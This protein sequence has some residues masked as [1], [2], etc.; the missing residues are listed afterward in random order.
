M[1][2][3]TLSNLQIAQISYTLCL[4]FL[5]ST[6]SACLPKSQ[7]NN[8]PVAIINDDMTVLVGSSVSLDSTQ[9]YDLD[10]DDL[11]FSWVLTSSPAASAISLENSF[12]PSIV[13]IPDTEG[14][15]TIELIVNDGEKDSEVTSVVVTAKTLPEIEISL[16]SGQGEL[17]PGA[18]VYLNGSIG[19]NDEEHFSYEWSLI[20]QPDG[21]SIVVENTNSLSF[22]FIPDTEGTFAF[23]LT[24]TDEGLVKDS[25]PFELL[26][27]QPI[28]DNA[29]P[30]ANA[31]AD[32]NVKTG[33]LVTLDGSVSS[34]LDL[35][36]ITYQWNIT[37]KPEG[38]SALLDNDTVQSPSF[39]A[40]FDGTYI[41]TLVVNDGNID[42]IED[43]VMVIAETQNV[44]PIA[45]TNS[46]LSGFIVN[47]LYSLDATASYDA[48]NDMLTYNWQLI[49]MPDEGAN[50]SLSSDTSV[51]S[52]FTTDTVGEY[53]ISLVVN[54]GSLDSTPLNLVFSVTDEDIAPPIADA[55]DD[56]TTTVGEEAILDGTGSYS[57]TIISYLWTL[58]SYPEGGEDISLIDETMALATFNPPVEGDYLFTLTVTDNKDQT[59]SDNVTVSVKNTAQIVAN[60]GPDQDVL[61]G[62]IVYL[63]ALGTTDE[64]SDIYSY[65]WSF[66]S[67][68]AD[69]DAIIEGNELTPTFVADVAGEY[70]ITLTVYGYSAGTSSDGIVVTARE[71]SGG[72]G[73]TTL[74]IQS[75]DDD[76]SYSEVDSV[77]DI[78]SGPL[79]TMGMTLDTFK[80]TANGGDITIVNL[81]TNINVPN[82]S[83]SF[84]GLESGNKISDG[85][86]LFFSTYLPQVTE[87]YNTITYSFEVFETGEIYTVNYYRVSPIVVITPK[88]PVD[89]ARDGIEGWVELEFTINEVGG[90]DDIVII[91]QYPDEV[92]ER[93]ASRALA[94]WKFTPTVADGAAVEVKSV[95]V[96]LEFELDS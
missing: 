20:S 24:I 73:N 33:T 86:S 4:L 90:V 79:S 8:Q 23:V 85:E 15:Y 95:R 42:S 31:G 69:S 71:P 13:F 58:T 5:I 72:S 21:S 91:D 36:V 37:S 25:Q 87:F 55:G 89:A 45:A 50:A 54:D 75:S 44:A 6:L 57:S 32:Q 14:E 52:T 7:E 46:D 65:D 12:Q 39:T 78:N 43:S 96:L 92:F 76:S 80:L 22:Q 19:E 82:T 62:D 56:Q 63:D 3:L 27:E 18:V 29:M 47:Q 48:D 9:S 26:I 93:E 70:V 10:G 40:D 61:V 68:P 53:I 38:S 66:Q 28:P 11:T 74:Y 59:A 84:V 1:T 88:Y 83:P 2:R 49:A 30:I 64:F 67:L 41:V 34:D 60:A 16:A 77:L 35:D 94:K 51:V 17:L 81:S